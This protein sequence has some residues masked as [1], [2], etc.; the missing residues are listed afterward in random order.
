[1]RLWR[2]ATYAGSVL[3]QASTIWRADRVSYPGWLLCPANARQAL[4]LATSAV[5]RRKEAL[6]SL[7]VQNRHQILYELSWRHRIGYWTLDDQTRELLSSV[8]DPSATEFLT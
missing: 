3:D 6:E 2:D 8:A 4:S 1:M 5:P 7:P